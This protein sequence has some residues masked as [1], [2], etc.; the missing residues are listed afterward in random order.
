MQVMLLIYSDESA[1]GR[2]SDAE[3]GAGFAA[4]GAYTEAL[5][6]AGAMVSG[7]PLQP[8]ATAHTVHVA[9]GTPQ[10]LDG[11]YAETREQLG[12]FYM[13]EVPDMATALHWAARCPGAAHGTIEVRPLMAMPA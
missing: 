7:A 2:M 11:P 4:Y 13:I 9:G 12:G 8:T 5:R 3:R 6:A 1:W 10:V